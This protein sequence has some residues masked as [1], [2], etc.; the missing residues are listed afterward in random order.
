MFCSLTG[1]YFLLLVDTTP[2]SD[3][4]KRKT[5][6]RKVDFPTC[7]TFLALNSVLEKL[8]NLPV[9]EGGGVDHGEMCFNN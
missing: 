2:P 5:E 3:V 8:S 7:L 1:K 4:K 9:S 6:E